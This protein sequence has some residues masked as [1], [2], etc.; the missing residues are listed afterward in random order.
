MVRR[1]RISKRKHLSRSLQRSVPRPV[2]SYVQRAIAK[3][4]ETHKKESSLNET[5]ISSVAT[6]PNYMSQVQYIA[7]GDTYYSRSAHQIKPIGVSLKFILHNNDT[8]GMFIRFVVLLN[9]NGAKDTDYTAGTD[10]FEDDGGNFGF[11]AASDRQR[12][13][14]RINKEKYKVLRDTIYKLGG[15][16]TADKM[17]YKKHWIPLRGNLMYDTSAAANPVRNQ[18]IPLWWICE[19]AEDE[20]TGKVVE[21]SV[22]SQFYFKDL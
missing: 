20:S 7:Q 3:G 8:A 21:L 10:L 1:S 15:D 18:L 6:A 9:I 12:L 2:K 22:T 16:N 13:T 14:A 4:K 11:A 17:I 5:Q 19:A